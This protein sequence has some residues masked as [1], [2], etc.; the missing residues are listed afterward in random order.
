MNLPE[1]CIKRPVFTTM[2][3]LLP[4]VLGLFALFSISVDQFPKVD[5]PVVVITTTRLGTS[6]EEMEV[7]VTKRIEEAINTIPGIDEGYH[8]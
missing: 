7:A 1:L 3:V 6:V 8:K 5:I 2:L 4:V